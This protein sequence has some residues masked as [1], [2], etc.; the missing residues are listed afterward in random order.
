M[1]QKV[2]E[3]ITYKKMCYLY[4]FFFTHLHL[5]WDHAYEMGLIPNMNVYQ[6]CKKNSVN[7][8][9]L[10]TYNTHLQRFGNPN[11]NSLQLR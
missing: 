2:Q 5:V 9:D 6:V 1:H 10:P 8:Y 4:T 11:H 3:S 7:K